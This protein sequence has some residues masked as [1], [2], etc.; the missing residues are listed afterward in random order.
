MAKQ[1]RRKR[2]YGRLIKTL[3]LVIAIALGTFLAHRNWTRIQLWAKGYDFAQQGAILNRDEEEI[4]DYLKC[5]HMIDINYWDEEYNR[6]H[7]YDYD[8]YQ[9]VSDLPRDK[10]INYIDALYT[11]M[12]ALN[13]LGYTK[14]FCREELTEWDITNYEAIIDNSLEYEKIKPYFEIK[15]AIFED[16][17]A[18]IASGMQ[19]LEAVLNITY[20]FVFGG[21]EVTRT[22]V[23]QDP[24]EL[25]TIGRK[26]LLINAGFEPEDLVEPKVTFSPGTTNTKL[27]K[28]AAKAMEKMVADAAAAGITI[29]VGRCYLSYTEQGAAYADIYSYWP[30]PYAS[31]MILTP[32]TDEHQLGLGADL[33]CPETQDAYVPWEATAAY[34]WLQEN[35]YRYGFIYRYPPSRIDQTGDSL[36]YIFYRYVGLDAAKEIY[37][38]G[39]DGTLEDY[40]YRHGFATDIDLVG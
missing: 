7:Y 1:K 9:S 10:I 26:G 31:S 21:A 40:V 30:E 33:T 37:E 20:P 8:Y 18:Y 13:D 22:F 29:W 6:Q 2:N 27:R 38:Y 11:L 28:E 15:G 12:P 24:T 14:E 4:Q 36:D 35:A 16:L 34:A 32:G 5:D 3:I 39:P 25:T 17:P 23:V 19:P